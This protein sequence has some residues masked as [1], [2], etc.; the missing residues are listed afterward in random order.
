MVLYAKVIIFW[1]LYLLIQ[2]ASFQ[3]KWASFHLKSNPIDEAYGLWKK[4]WTIFKAFLQFVGH[5][6]A[7]YPLYPCV[8]DSAHEK[9]WMHRK[10]NKYNTGNNNEHSNS[11]MCIEEE[12]D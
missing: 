7:E 3:F 2:P 8:C 6:W 4:I 11:D 5:L 1:F 9:I 10:L 12:E